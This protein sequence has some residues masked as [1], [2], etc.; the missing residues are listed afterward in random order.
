M[1]D[2]SNS[3]TYGLGTVRKNMSTTFRNS[4]MFSHEYEI[5]EFDFGST[6]NYSDL[7]GLMAPR[8]FMAQRGHADGVAWDEYVGYE[9][10]L[11]RRLY[12]QLKIPE[13]TAIRWFDGGHEIDVEAAIEFFDRFLRK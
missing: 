6:F 11:V 10:A 9:Y 2:K 3:M 4:Y 8:P 1:A 5:F 13:R 7:A 12:T